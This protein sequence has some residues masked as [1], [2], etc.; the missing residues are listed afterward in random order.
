MRHST[1]VLLLILIA[2]GTAVAALEARLG[3]ISGTRLVMVLI[4]CR[5]SGH[6]DKEQ[7]CSWQ[8]SVH[9]EITTEVQS[10]VQT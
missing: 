8:G 1:L 3:A 10:R 7:R 5:K 6:P 9:V 4:F 2:L